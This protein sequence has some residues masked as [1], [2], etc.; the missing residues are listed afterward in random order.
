MSS[1][2]TD[3]EHEPKHCPRCGRQFRCNADNIRRCECT[4]VE[5]SPDARNKIRQ[6][7]AD[8][9]CPFCLRGLQGGMQVW[10]ITGQVHQ[11]SMIRISCRPPASSP[12]G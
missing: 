8:C 12:G 10:R 4:S 9:L 5:L 1:T 6:L 2:T 3:S 7:Y 11:A